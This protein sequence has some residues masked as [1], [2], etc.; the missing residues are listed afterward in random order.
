RLHE[1]RRRLHRLHDA[2]LSGQ[3]L[4]VLQDTARCNYFD[5]VFPRR[6]LGDPAPAPPDQSARQHRSAVGRD[7]RGSER[8]GSGVDAEP[9]RQGG[10]LLLRSVA[11]DGSAE[12]WPSTW[13][14]RSLL[15]RG[16]TWRERRLRRQIRDPRRRCIV[17]DADLWR[18][19]GVWTGVAALVV[20]I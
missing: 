2:G 13:R 5:D 14:R 19:W 1:S 9:A 7:E 10:S 8:M 17:T 6:R 11:G 4:A 3:V 20:V 15:G 18:A 12:A 16:S